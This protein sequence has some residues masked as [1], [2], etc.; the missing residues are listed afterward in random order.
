[1][2]ELTNRWP[3]AAIWLTPTP[4]NGSLGSCRAP[5]IASKTQIEQRDRLAPFRVIRLAR[6]SNPQSDDAE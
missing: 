6:A 3:P 4:W 2:N 1:M 5:Q